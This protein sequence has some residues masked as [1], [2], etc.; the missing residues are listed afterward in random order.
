VHVVGK[1]Q[2]FEAMLAV[3]L[4]GPDDQ[5]IA[6]GYARASQGAPEWG[7]FAIDFYY[8]PPATAQQV[9]L[10]AYEPSPKDGSPNSLV[11]TTVV[12]VPVPDLVAWKT[13]EN[14]THSFT[15][16]YPPTWHLNQG[17]IMPAPPLATKFSTYQ[18]RTP[19]EPLGEG[20]AEIWITVSD[21]P[22]VAEM[23]NLKQKGY[24][25]T[26]VVVG[27]RQG[28]RYTATQPGHG[29]YDVV[30]TLSGRR[31]YRIQIS[32]ATH[33]FD[34]TFALVLGTFTVSE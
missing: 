14:P 16:R 5:V 17:S 29:V 15:V 11:E 24:K 26:A 4:V 7:D 22:S 6:T 18:V 31:E 3:T 27:G 12:L 19:G 10:Q 1:A 8:P 13:F 21:V 23:E 32:A 34:W 25:E 9:T 20:E 28:V 33:N 30:Y 2:V